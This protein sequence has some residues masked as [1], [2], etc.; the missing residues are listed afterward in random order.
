MAAFL[1]LVGTISGGGGIVIALGILAWQSL[2]WLQVGTW[3]PLTIGDGFSYYQTDPPSGQWVG[4][5]KIILSVLNLPLSLS[6]FLVGVALAAFVMYY[7][8]KIETY[9]REQ[10]NAARAK[11]RNKK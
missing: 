7:A 8:E 4:L 11:E 2:I 1:Y 3:P 5:E 6:V 9:K 10:R